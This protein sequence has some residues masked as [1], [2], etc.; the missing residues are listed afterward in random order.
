M[1]ALRASGKSSKLVFQIPLRKFSAAV[2]TVKA[3]NVRGRIGPHGDIV[4]RD[5]LNHFLI[6]GVGVVKR[7]FKQSNN[8]RSPTFLDNATS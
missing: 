8:N 5:I 4:D 7:C 6:C 2:H 3:L 1:C